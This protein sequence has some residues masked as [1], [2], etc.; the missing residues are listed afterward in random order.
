MKKFNKSMNKTLTNIY[1]TN[2]K[3]AKAMDRME[4]MLSD[5]FV[6]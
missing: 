4:A 5:M 1:N 6:F 3:A 2:P